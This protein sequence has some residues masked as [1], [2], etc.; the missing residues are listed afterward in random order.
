D[1][2]ADSLTFATEQGG[3]YQNEDQ[4]ESV[5]TNESIEQDQEQAPRKKRARHSK[6]DAGSRKRVRGRQGGLKGL[7]KMPIEIF[8]EIAYLLTPSDLIALSWSSKFFR[9]ILLQRSAVKM[10]RRAESNVSG[11]PPCPA[12]MCEP[13]YAVLVFAKYCTL[14]PTHTYVPGSVLPVGK[15][16]AY[17]IDLS[18]PDLLGVKIRLKEVPYSLTS[19]R[20]GRN[21]VD[22]SECPGVKTHSASRSR[23][24]QQEYTL[25]HMIDEVKQQ[26]Q[27]FRNTGDTEGLEEWEEHRSTL[28]QGRHKFG[29]K[30]H[31]YLESVSKSREKEL[32][33]MR[34]QRRDEI[35]ERLKALGW[36]D[37][38]LMFRFVDRKQWWPLIE[39]PKPLTD[40]I[41]NNILP[42]LT[43]VLEENREKQAAYDKRE[44]RSARRH[45]VNKFLLELRNTPHPLEPIF[46][47]LRDQL[48][49]APAPGTSDSLYQPGGP[50][51]LSDY[52]LTLLKPGT[53]YALTWDS[54]ADLSER[55]ITVEEVEAELEVRKESIRNKVLEWRDAVE[56]QLV[57]QFES[58]TE[59][60]PEA[61]ILTASSTELTEDLP[62]ELR[63]LLR[64]DTV[65]K[66]DRAASEDEQLGLEDIPS[67]CYFPKLATN[68][69][70]YFYDYPALTDSED[71]YPPTQDI[72]LTGYK[73]NI[74]VEHIVKLLLKDLE[75]PNA[76]RLELKVIQSRFV[77]GR[78]ID[79][80][81][82]NWDQMISHYIDA[83]K[84]WESNKDNDPIHPLRYPI[85]YQN[86]HDLESTVKN[87]PL[88][89]L[90]TKQ[91]A[92]DLRD[93]EYTATNLSKC[94]LCRETG[95]VCRRFDPE[96]IVMHLLDVHDITKPVEGVHY[97]KLEQGGI[98][99]EWSKMWDAF[100]DAQSS[101]PIARPSS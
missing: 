68:H 50:A 43:P 34:K 64:A 11:L 86:V 15:T 12:G 83:P 85:A 51:A 70:K 52:K 40:R 44:R 101:E 93:S 79:K 16:S 23:G 67:P 87:R 33:H 100:H 4:A 2:D 45:R 75:M 90:L 32:D 14:N 1:L 7:M 10:W 78:C 76:S 73:R 56:R 60:I 57:N 89:R 25:Q 5:A 21:L 62:R 22:Y 84:K 54:L 29:D 35:N 71:E 61:T 31:E 24:I 55:E 58:G 69:F 17:D 94:Y 26:Q 39:A 28:V 47:V 66:N 91:E 8:T 72:D 36:T 20:T 63:V 48:D 96:D 77:C 42:K 82:K 98:S 30:L 46:N 97:G 6:T 37:K 81:P 99:D 80:E 65:F 27:V 41:W 53:K 88:V 74:R 49:P 19:K 95:R 92:Q 38:E 18:E 3:V 9:T 59:I 13:Q